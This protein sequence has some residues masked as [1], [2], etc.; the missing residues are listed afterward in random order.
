ML[1]TLLALN[2]GAIGIAFF[3]C[4]ILPTIVA[5]LVIVTVQNLAP[6]AVEGTTAAA[7]V[8]ILWAVFLAPLFAGYLVAR[9]SKAL[10]LLHGLVVSLVGSILYVIYLSLTGSTGLLSL[11]VVPP[12]ILAGM[13]GAWFFSYRSKRQSSSAAG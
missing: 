2:I 6:S 12:V 5:W 8:L 13:S 11:L 3:G 10:P 9:L 4:Y 7:G 1:R